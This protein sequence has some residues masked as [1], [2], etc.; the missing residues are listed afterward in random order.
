MELDENVIADEAGKWWWAIAL[1]GVLWL[2]IG[3]IVLRLDL[4]SITAVGFLIGGMFLAA[5]V[6]EMMHASATRGGWKWLHYGLGVV[7]LLGSLWAFVR[8]IESVFALAS[9]LGFILLLMGTFDVVRAISTKG[10]DDLWWIPLV[11]GILLILLAVWVSQRFYPARI[12]LILFWVGFMSIFRGIG[13]IAFGFAVRR[14]GKELR[15]AGQMA[16]A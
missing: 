8:P 14:A 3:F 5:A 13:H 12:E 16:T 15:A 6:D 10:V 11:T 9:V 1:I 2:W 4:T 7:F